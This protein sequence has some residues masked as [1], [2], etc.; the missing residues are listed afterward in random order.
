MRTLTVR[1][2]RLLLYGG[3]GI[4]VYLLLFGG[5]KLGGALERRSAAYHQLVADARELKQELKAYD[6]RVLVVKRMM[7]HYQLDP[8]K[9][10]RATV[11]GL[12]SAQMQKVAAGSGIQVGPVRESPA[13]TSAREMAT[14]QLEGSGPIPAVLGLLQRMETLGWPVII[15]SVQITPDS[16][17][18]GQVKI[19]L[20]AV[21]LDFDQWK[22]EGKPHA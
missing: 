14:L 2:K 21:V 1:E 18:P 22:T 11:V 10:N 5:Y 3:I 13:K 4:G 19:I 20:S 8:A 15:D 7:D 6:D 9:L 17:R 16:M 12:A